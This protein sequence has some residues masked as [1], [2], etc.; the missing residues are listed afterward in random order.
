MKTLFLLSG[1]LYLS[2][3]L[4]GQSQKPIDIEAHAGGKG[5]YP[6]NSIP[7]FVNALKLGVTT[8][9]MDCVISQDSMVVV[10]H[11]PFMNHV[12][13]LSPT[14]KSI[15][16]QEEKNHNLFKMP[17]DSIRQYQLGSKFDPEFA[18]QKLVKTY[19]PL[20]REVI[21]SVESYIR[22]HNL[23]PL[24]YNI[25]I[26]SYHQA[27]DMTPEPQS[28]ADLVL[29]IILEYNLQN[30]VLIQ[31]FDVRPLQYIRKQYPAIKISYLLSKNTPLTLEQNLAK[32]G[33]IPQVLSPEYPMVTEQMVKTARKHKMAIIPWTIDSEADMRKYIGMGVDGI[34][35]NYPD[36]LLKLLSQQ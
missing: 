2:F 27:M 36:L 20:L 13:M 19:K 22:Q 30:R 29:A 26:K 35:T 10:S 28:F 21:D 32:L 7:A 34:I 23:K 8:L 3:C 33:F 11:D 17:Y 15:S 9:E 24:Q 14:G 18:N 5:L 16:K 12:F 1:L 31:S 4:Y 6:G 25:E